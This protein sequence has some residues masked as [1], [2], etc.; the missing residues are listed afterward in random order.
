MCASKMSET[1]V[2][3]AVVGSLTTVA[4]ELLAS[5]P[6]LGKQVEIVRVDD[7]LPGVEQYDLRVVG[8]LVRDEAPVGFVR[9]SYPRHQ[10]VKNKHS[11]KRR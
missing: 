1:K 4:T 7:L 9:P 3:V 10:N 2:R 6:E 8:K 11:K 5:H